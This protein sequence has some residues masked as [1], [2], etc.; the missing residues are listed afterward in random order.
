[1]RNKTFLLGA[2][3][4]GLLAA[5]PA[6]AQDT[7]EDRPFQGL[8][9]AGSVGFDAQP[10]D[11][12]EAVKFDRNLDG[13][14]GDTVTTAA[15]A[16]AFSPGFCN[17][18]ARSA[19]PIDGCVNDRDSYSYSGRVGYDRQYGHIVVGAVVEGG[20][21]NI[22]D[23]V[24][25]FSTTPA[26]YTINRKLQFVGNARLRAG[27]A[28]DKTLF[29]GTGGF[30]YAKVNNYFRTTNTTNGFRSNGDSDAYGFAAG[31]G[32]EQ[33][34]GQHFSL[35]LEY[36]FN[37]VNNDDYRVRVSGGPATSP[38]LQ[39]GA[40]G[41]DLARSYRFFKWHSVRAVAAFRF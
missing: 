34:I 14:F 36:L 39:G 9:V 2:A 25:A 28:F 24:S 37:R 40:G 10:N 8:Y 11:V 31:G 17:G 29:Y 41:T 27:Y 19:Q 23:A 15:G 26:S 20:Y 18:Q 13:T 5:A 33:K 32:V 21:S 6:F 35:G 7:A 12:G 4:A 16:N 3:F 38:F 30:E 22:R 1:M